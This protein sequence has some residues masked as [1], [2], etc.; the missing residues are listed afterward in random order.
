MP[1]SACLSPNGRSF[2]RRGR[3][4]RQ[5]AAARSPPSLSCRSPSVPSP[6][7][8]HR[9]PTRSRLLR[10]RYTAPAQGFVSALEIDSKAKAEEDLVRS[11]FEEQTCVSGEEG[12]ARH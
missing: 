10:L 1:A 3:G 4:Y 2:G 5:E 8:G 6:A 7:R 12:A 11:R 9:T